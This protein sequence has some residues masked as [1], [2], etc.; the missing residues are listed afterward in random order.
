MYRG[1]PRRTVWGALHMST[2]STKRVI[3]QID[4]GH[5]RSLARVDK[6]TYVP[7]LIEKFARSLIEPDEELIRVLYYDC[8]PFEG[9]RKQPISGTER[10]FKRSAGWLQDLASRD[11]FAVRLGV[12]KWRGWKPRRAPAEGKSMTDADFLPDFEQ[13]GVDLRIGLDIATYSLPRQVDRI[14]LVTGDTDLIPAMKLARR[15]GVQIVGIEL[16]KR[17]PSRELL[18]HTDLC[19]KRSWPTVAP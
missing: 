13:K 3:V 1:P 6:Q 16:G 14:I 11:L 7:D 9:K 5:L 12:L 15:S 8:A 2:L 4:G 18:A 19:R 17:R 10:E